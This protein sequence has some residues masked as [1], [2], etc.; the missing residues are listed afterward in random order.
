M[1]TSNTIG[2]VIMV[3]TKLYQKEVRCE[4]CV[5]GGGISGFCTAIAAAREGISVVLVHD[6]P[7]L[8]GNASS[9]IRMSIGG[10]R[11]MRYREG[12]I[13]EE[14]FLENAAH[15]PYSRY[16]LWDIVL[17]NMIVREK[18]IRLL[19]NCT[20]LNAECDQDRITSV[21]CYMMPS[22]TWYTIH[23]K[24]FA[25][26]SG[27]S[28]LAPLTGAHFRM[29]SDGK[30]A[31]GEATAPDTADHCTMGNS[32]MMQLERSAY[33]E[34]F[35]EPD[36]ADHFGSDH[37][38]LQHGTRDHSFADNYSTNFWWMERGGTKDTISD[39]DEIRHSLLSLALGVYGH[40]KN[41][42]ADTCSDLTINW[43]GALPG[44]RESRRYVGPHTLT[45]NDISANRS[46]P[47]TVAYGGWPMDDHDPRGFD[48]NG[49][50]CV[51][52]PV[53]MP[54]QIPL[55][56]LYSENIK[57]LWFAGR[58]ISVS[59]EALTSTRVSATCA[60]LGQA[61]GTAAAAAIQKQCDPHEF[62][63]SD[64]DD[65]RRTLLLRDCYL[66][67]ATI[68]HGPAMD[69]IDIMGTAANT[70]LAARG[71]DDTFCSASS[72][73][74]L[75]YAFP[76]ARYIQS[77]ELYFDSDFERST[78]TDRPWMAGSIMNVHSPVEPY[79]MS[80]PQTLP[81]AFEITTPEGFVFTVTDNIHR[82]VSIPIKGAASAVTFR[83]LET[84]GNE[85]IAIHAMELL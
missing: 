24:Q 51:C 21:D 72:G 75:T 49:P 30:A 63:Q 27:D 22:Q 3:Q 7:V 32:I 43:L 23:A 65:I 61:A 84:T 67:E 62:T 69:Q 81:K 40:L 41:E 10:I 34:P 17:Y 47:D 82:H 53:P 54:Y 33:T 18:N 15:N 85:R 59:H 83:L 38:S 50:G 74:T 9:E 48:N 11:D 77:V 42:H 64:V 5:I 79:R 16:P 60:L 2:G 35:T 70:A 25:D 58:N 78:C 4:L 28:I 26:C 68:P 46:Y 66:P 73:D 57:N 76:A 39:A 6:R 44:K 29:G 36:W 80:L 45:A 52:Y 20:C 1:I 14:L 37:I 13:T 56:C 12:G 8:G 71:L 31:F 55:R 19:L